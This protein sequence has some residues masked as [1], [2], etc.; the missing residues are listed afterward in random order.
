MTTEYTRHRIG[1]VG[2]GIATSLSPALHAHEAA[3]LGLDDY[4]Y[5]L[6]DLENLNISVE[7]TGEVVRGAVAG[8]F[9]G[10][11][12]THPCKQVVVDA[13][14][15]LSGNARLLGAVN[16]V[17]VDNGRLIGHNTDH[18]GF[19]TALQRG[20][21]DAALDRVVLAGAGGAGSA[22]AYALAAAGTTDLRIADIDPDRAVDVCSRVTS[23]FPGTRTTALAID[24]IAVNL[25]TCDGVVNASPIGMVGH[26]GT[27]FDPAALHSGL[28]FA[29][30][31]YRPMRTEL[32]DAAA[33]LG[34]A[35]LDGGQMLVAQAS[36]T[37]TL[38]TGVEAD[39]DRMRSHLSELLSETACA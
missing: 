18:S 6:I 11:N 26:P 19:L 10:L 7:K 24:E 23:A 32:L 12:I 1:L 14:D 38:L 22:V 39:T 5:E 3:A 30:I 8:D 25:T 35:V 31:V 16:T 2:S 9:T 36:D 13:L 37:F 33:A 28:W 27:P 21:P 15:E 29:D 4:S 34:C 17:V 20:L